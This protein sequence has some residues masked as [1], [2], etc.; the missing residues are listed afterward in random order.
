M[1]SLEPDPDSTS[2]EALTQACDA[3]MLINGL[4][5]LVNSLAPTVPADTDL[6]LKSSTEEYLTPG[7]PSDIMHRSPS[8][9]GLVECVNASHF[10]ELQLGFTNLWAHGP[11]MYAE[12]LRASL[13]I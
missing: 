5:P 6:T 12:A 9:P 11:H 1:P 3:E 4:A 10:N 13:H 2:L 8:V 7:M